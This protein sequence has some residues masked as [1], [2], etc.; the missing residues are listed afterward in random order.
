MTV[1]SLRPE[2]LLLGAVVAASLLAS[3]DASAGPGAD[4][5]YDSASRVISDAQKDI[6]SI[7]AAVAAGRTTDRGASQRVA[8]GDL[9]LRNRDYDRAAVIFNE[10]IEKYSAHPTAHAEALHLLGETYYRSQQLLSARRVYLQVVDSSGSDRLAPYAANALARLV[11]IAM[12]TRD[13]KSLDDIFARMSKV[14]SASV[15][16]ILAY[17]RGRGLVARKDFEVARIALQGVPAASPYHHQA[18][19]LLGV[20]ATK[21]AQA[22]AA[23]AAKADADPSKPAGAKPDSAAEMASTRGRY[24]KA[25]EAFREVTR[26]SPDTPEH[27][28][29]ID[30]AW[31]AIGRL[32]YET[33]QW[34]ASAEAYNHVDRN[35]PEFGKMLYELASV[36]VRLGDVQ[37][38]QRALE[39][40]SIA[41]PDSSDIAEGNL[42]RGD[43]LLRTGQFKKSL[44]TYEGVR[45]QYD[46]M[47]VKVD[48]FLGATNDPA[49]YY[50]RLSREQLDIG[51]T[52]AQLPPLAVQWAR[53]AEDG[54]EAFAVLD[55]VVKTRALIK[56]A[57]ALVEKLGAVTNAPNRIRAFPEL[58]AGEQKALSLLN[59][60]MRARVTLA[61]GLDDVESGSVEGE[62]ETVR[63]ER[64]T[65]QR[66]VLSLPVSE[67]EFQSI[68]DQ[69]SRE[70]NTVSQHVQ[71]LTLQIDTLQALVNGLRR[72]LRDSASQGVVR[73]PGS[74]R[75][76][77]EDLAANEREIA[78]YRQRVVELRKLIDAGRL[79][80]GFGDQRYVHDAD[81]R[82]RFK[83]LLQR[84]VQLAS[85]GAGGSK[86][87]SYAVRLAPLLNQADQSDQAI[88]AARADIARQVQK[89]TRELQE[90]VYVESNR[91]MDYAARLE[92]LDQE[93]RLVVGQVAMRNFGL[94]R[95]RLKNIVLRA[96]V[97][98]TEEAWEVREEQLTRVRNLLTE[99]A[100]SERLLDEEL[101][102]VLDDA[103]EESTG[104]KR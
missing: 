27:R 76:L 48:S 94:V 63:A 73:D 14:P 58:R 71:Q 92:K 87:V 26:L 33:D 51:N 41:D 19:Y 49:V 70:W 9:A 75:R 99:R 46:P 15:E 25:V 17:A 61:E 6:P 103:G 45:K 42:L 91:I 68:D 16:S 34:H 104:A 80:S 60:M 40:L 90:Q 5:A 56:Q 28:H 65:L 93:A 62:I 72:V 24:A 66:Q 31:M 86:A 84:E 78:A 95:D 55:E 4:E 69:A 2:R 20:I 1:L 23:D 22:A 53:E 38:A 10:V 77:E 12:R 79:A 47:R 82:E 83:T 37:R 32:F 67:A 13:L 81:L 43:L 35:S 29:V 44:E 88:N 101:R 64:R 39:V 54:P 57:Q 89:K 96:D 52:D 11:D 102:E 100:R 3:A 21:E 8:E 18:R 98:I 50:D 74:Q 36:Y 97:G 85:Q 7:Q 30:L 59:A